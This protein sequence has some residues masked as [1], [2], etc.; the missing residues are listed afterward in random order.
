MQLKNNILASFLFFV[1]SISIAQDIPQGG[2]RKSSL[3]SWVS[4]LPLWQWFE[5]PNTALSSA[6][7]T[8]PAGDYGDVTSKISDWVG[9]ALKREGSFYIIGMVG[10][11]NDYFGNEVDAL[12]LNT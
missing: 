12:E 7:P 10:G 6:P 9:A 3:P 4:A 8:G 11:H 1:I 5:I 2:E